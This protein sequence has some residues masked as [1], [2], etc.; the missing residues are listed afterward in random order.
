MKNN[1]K[2]MKTIVS[3][4]GLA[5]VTLTANHLN[6]QYRGLFG[7]SK[8]SADYDYNG[9]NRGLMN[10]EGNTESGIS[11]YGIGEEVPM[12][13]GLLILSL[14]GAGYAAL[15]RKRSRKGTTLLLACVLLLGFTQCK[16][17]Q[18]VEPTQ[19]EGVRIT[20]TVDSGN[21][22]GVDAESNSIY[23]K[24]T[25]SCTAHAATFGIDFNVMNYQD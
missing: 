20:L 8:S 10:I 13:S 4:L 22:I 5:A 14:A 18:T 21:N 7:M 16:K 17:D 2:T 12:G 19:N 6:A 24:Y 15:R 11:N 25:A 23:H 3:S 1:L 9:N